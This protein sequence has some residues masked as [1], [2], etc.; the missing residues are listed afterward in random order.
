MSMKPATT[1]G[2]YRSHLN[3]KNPTKA[4]PPLQIQDR[5]VEII[6]AVSENRFLTRPMLTRLFPPNQTARTFKSA[7]PHDSTHSNLQKRLRALFW[8]DY[9]H[10]FKIEIDGEF[11]YALDTKGARLLTSRQ[12]PLPLTSTVTQLSKDPAW[13][14]V[15]HTLMTANFRTSLEAALR[16]HP[17]YEL[18]SF[19]RSSDDIK[20]SWERKDKT[21]VSVTPD[22]FAVFHDTAKPAGEQEKMGFF[23]ECDRQTKTLGKLTEQL[24]K[25]VWM[26]EDR[27]HRNQ[28]KIDFFRVILITPSEDRAT[29]AVSVAT[30]G[31]KT[32]L[33]E[34]K[35][36]PE[37]QLGL[38]YI[39]VEQVYA[40]HPTN[41]L[42]AVYRRFN[43]PQEIT[44]FIPSPLPRK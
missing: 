39:T 18:S 33:Y 42:A 20:V 5:D 22:A 27:V 31:K 25:Y 26:F 9:L 35:P 34:I 40:K 1:R 29:N 19:Q 13:F 36:L 32:Q 38:F 11:I 2:S 41:T 21:K 6:H 16:E 44:S 14:Q 23:I 17:T 12:L 43:K 30:Y 7:N 37:K 24:R 4:L 15:E 8:H 3:K 28:F 10:R